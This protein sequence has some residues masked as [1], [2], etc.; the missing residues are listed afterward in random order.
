MNKVAGNV[1]TALSHVTADTVIKMD[2]MILIRDLWGG[3]V[4]GDVGN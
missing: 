2:V 3:I 4:D 1:Y